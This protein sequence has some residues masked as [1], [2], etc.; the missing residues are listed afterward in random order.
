M[1]NVEVVSKNAGINKQ[2]FLIYGR[3]K[4]GKST[5]AHKFPE[6]LFLATEAGQGNLEGCNRIIVNSWEKF[7]EAGGEIARGEIKVINKDGK[8]VLPETVVI[9][10]YDNLCMYATEWVCKDKGIDEIG[11]YKKFGAYHI[12]T[13]LIRLKLA[14]L[15]LL[16]YGL[17]LISHN[18]LLEIETKVKKYNMMSIAVGGQN[19]DVALNLPDI[20]LFMD[21]EMRD[22]KEVG[23]IRTKPSMYWHAGDRSKKLPSE[24]VFDLAK[25]EEAY[26]VLEGCFK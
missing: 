21:S 18:K 10:T 20:I 25:P 16:P 6:P 24:I 3:P 11:D 14:K 22:Q 9:D 5:L 12:V 8:E 2:T 15:S 19:K 7:L 1:S 26:K 17:V 4:I 23:I 13:N